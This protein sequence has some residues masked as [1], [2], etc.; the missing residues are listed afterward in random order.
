M[1]AWAETRETP[2]QLTA[3]PAS[4]ESSFLSQHNLVSVANEGVVSHWNALS[5]N[6]DN[7]RRLW[8]T[9]PSAYA[10]AVSP[11]GQ[12]TAVG[13]VGCFVDIFDPHGEKNLRLSI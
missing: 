6:N 4:A 12:F 5:L 8:C 9:P 3:I 7:R 11:D 13:G 2:Q 1:V 10:A